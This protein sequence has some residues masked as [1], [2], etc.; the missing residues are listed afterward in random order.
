MIAI[1]FCLVKKSNI[2][3]SIKY[4]NKNGQKTVKEKDFQ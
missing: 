3:S 2:Y 4:K 1:A